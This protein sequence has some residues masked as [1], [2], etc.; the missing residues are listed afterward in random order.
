T[1]GLGGA[2]AELLA[3]HEPTPMEFIGVQNRFGESGN[4]AE[5]IKHFGMAPENII[6]A[7]KLAIGKKIK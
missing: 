3:K 2:V 5:L 4:P 7:V 6:A 1:G